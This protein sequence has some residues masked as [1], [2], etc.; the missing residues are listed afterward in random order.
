M[1]FKPYLL[2]CQVYARKHWASMLC[3]KKYKQKCNFPLKK[4]LKEHWCMNQQKLYSWTAKKICSSQCDLN[5]GKQGDNRWCYL[6]NIKRCINLQKMHFWTKKTQICRSQY[7]LNPGQQSHR[8]WS[9]HRAIETLWTLFWG[10][11]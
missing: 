7:E 8:F 3:K 9:Y 1:L 10:T 4:P 11:Y 5:P 2:K 6:R